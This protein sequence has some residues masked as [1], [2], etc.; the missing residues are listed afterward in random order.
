MK[1]FQQ[2][3]KMSYDNNLLAPILSINFLHSS[4]KNVEWDP[5]LDGFIFFN[6]DIK[7][8]Q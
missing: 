8:T 6:S 2:A 5:R 4:T 7:F 3:W 1:A